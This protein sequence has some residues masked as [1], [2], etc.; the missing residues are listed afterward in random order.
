MK[1]QPHLDALTRT[2]DFGIIINLINL[3]EYNII[4]FLTFFLSP[5]QFILNLTQKHILNFLEHGGRCA[6]LSIVTEAIDQG[7]C[8]EKVCIFKQN[9]CIIALLIYQN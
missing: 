7:L 4:F 8:N 9:P 2:D 6:G 5:N 3:R 1:T